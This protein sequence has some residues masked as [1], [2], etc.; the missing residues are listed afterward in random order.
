MSREPISTSAIRTV[1]HDGGDVLEL[2]FSGGSVVTIPRRAEVRRRCAE[3]LLFP[4]SILRRAHPDMYLTE[5]GGHAD[6]G[7]TP[8]RRR[9]R[10]PKPPPTNSKQS[11]IVNRG[12]IVPVR[13]WRG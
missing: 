13:I 3:E 7:G 2:E 12:P 5:D 9:P 11:P 1:G 6:C 4:G 8:A 10:K